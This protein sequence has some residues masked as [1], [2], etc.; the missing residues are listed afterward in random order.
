MHTTKA[1]GVALLGLA[2]GAGA[3]LAQI[4]GRV[5]GKVLDENGK[6]VPGVKITI[7]DPDV[8]GRLVE[9]VS[10]ELGKYQLVIHDATKQLPWRMEKEGFHLSEA[11]RK[12]PANTTTELDLRIYSL[13]V[14]PPPSAGIAAEEAEAAKLKACLLY[15][16]PSPRD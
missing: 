3:L 9:A 6:P 13:A 14:V 4:T 16:S 11:M 8:K 15:T 5:H 10:D 7:T 1:I 12:V 2:V